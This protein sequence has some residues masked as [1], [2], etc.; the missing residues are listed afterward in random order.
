MPVDM[1]RRRADQI[2]R[3]PDHFFC[4]AKSSLRRMCLKELPAR[5]AVNQVA[6]QIRLH[7]TRCDAIHADAIPRPL[8]RQSAD[9]PDHPALAGAVGKHFDQA[10]EA[11]DARNVD[12]AAAPAHAPQP[13]APS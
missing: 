12:D 2:D 7:H 4:G 3:R 5:R 8:I 11:V 10:D 13:I 1:A 9:D 6:I